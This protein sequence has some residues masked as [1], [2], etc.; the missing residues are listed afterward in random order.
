VSSS[1]GASEAA[2]PEDANAVLRDGPGAK[3]GAATPRL[4]E[5]TGLEVTY[6]GA[7][8]VR[9]VSL[10]VERGEIVGL[11]GPNGAGKSST[12]NAISGDLRPAKGSVRLAGRDV[13]KLPD[14]RRAR[15]GM[16]RT[17]QTARVF[18]G[19]TVF[20][21]LVTVARGAVGASV[22]RTVLGLG[23]RTAEQDAAAL[24]WRTLDQAG[25]G[26]IAN[27]YGHELSGGQRRFVDL[28]MALIRSPDLLLLDEPMVGVAPALL[29]GLMDQLRQIR[30]RG[31]GIL[32]VEHALE[33]VAE[34]CDRIIV[35]VWGAI[36]AEGTH[37]EITADPEVR[38]AYL[39]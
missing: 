37:D 18:E 6:G 28:A 23:Q 32:I 16:A 1:G 26:H 11:I 22:M 30:G 8:A 19:M 14:F 5:V 27:L 31:A 12:L 15:L 3:V 17:S 10:A 36:I 7:P 2:L 13:T 21:A 20:E 33:I 9:G 25:F 35:M 24:A 38:R 29:P 4:L 39:T 34:L